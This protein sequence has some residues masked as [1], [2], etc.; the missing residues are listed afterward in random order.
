MATKKTTKKTTKP[1]VK[2]TTS[3]HSSKTD[4]KTL[5]IVGLLLNV[6]IWPGLGTL[7]NKDISK[8]VIQ[9]ILFVIAVPLSFIL[10]GIPLL[11][12]VWIWALL[13]SVKQLQA[14]E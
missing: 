8:G 13:T 11:L 1:V 2:K 14:A 7:I 4:D 12:G 6:L 3:K 5:V 9:M 10:I